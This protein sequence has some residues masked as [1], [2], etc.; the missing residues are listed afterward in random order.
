MIRKRFSNLIPY[1]ILC[2]TLI[3]TCFF[4]EGQIQFNLR[5]EITLSATIINLLIYIFR[6]KYGIVAPCWRKRPL[7]PF[8]KEFNI[9]LQS[10][11]YLRLY[12]TVRK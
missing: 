12:F 3:Y 5:E 1:L 10:I 6:F 9:M 11:F 7:V 4:K 8:S 2:I